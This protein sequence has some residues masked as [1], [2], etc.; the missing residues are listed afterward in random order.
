[1]PVP[2]D[3]CIELAKRLRP[4][5]I[6]PPLP[7]GTHVHEPALVQNA[8]VSRHAR[9][10][11]LHRADDVV[12]GLLAASQ[13][14]HD[15]EPDGIGEHLNGFNMHDRIYVYPCIFKCQDQASR[16]GASPHRSKDVEGGW[17]R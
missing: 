3:P 16:I 7:V 10:V 11:D 1:M 9:L 14:V 4:Q 2:A 13:H 8:Q 6:H 15:V 17:S 12:D 5:R